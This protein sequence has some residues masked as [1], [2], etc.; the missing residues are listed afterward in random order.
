MVFFL[1]MV[2]GLSATLES[3]FFF[4]T[5]HFVSL[6]LIINFRDHYFD[7]PSRA[8]TKGKRKHGTISSLEEA[9]RGARGVREYH[10][11]DESKILP[12]KRA[13]DLNFDETEEL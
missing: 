8:R 3:S 4:G 9:P 5:S 7:H 1:L 6:T 11:V 13:F 10:K 2:N 12:E